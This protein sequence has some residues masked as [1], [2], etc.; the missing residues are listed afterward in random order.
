MPLIATAK[1]LRHLPLT[2]DKVIT[3]ACDIAD[4]SP[5][6]VCDLH[7]G[8][9]FETSPRTEASVDGATVST[10]TSVIRSSHVEY[11]TSASVSAGSDDDDDGKMVCKQ[12]QLANTNVSSM[13]CVSKY[14]YC[15]DHLRDG[16][17]ERDVLALLTP[18]NTTDQSCR[19][20]NPTIEK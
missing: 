10:T 14:D 7:T 6:L 19:A 5:L 2:A 17:K 13:V 1:L 18:S 12:K 20:H 11:S 15:T 9:M 4:A 3:Y 8:A 16:I